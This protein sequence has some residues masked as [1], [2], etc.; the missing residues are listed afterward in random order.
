LEF[1]FKEFL[2]KYQI[3]NQLILDYY[4]RDIYREL[5]IDNKGINFYNFREYINLPEYLSKNLFRV[6]SDNN[7]II[8][9]NDFLTNINLLYEG[10]F[11]QLT[12]II[13]KFLDF[14]GDGK[15]NC[16]DVKQI[17]I[18][19]LNSKN[20]MDHI[21]NF[22]EKNI[23]NFF[24][25]NIQMDLERFEYLTENYN[26]DIFINLIT[27]FYE[28][29]PFTNEII[30]YYFSDKRIENLDIL[31]KSQSKTNKGMKISNDI[32]L[33]PIKLQKSK[34]I[35]EELN[36]KKNY[37][38]EQNVITINEP[39]EKVESRRSLEKAFIKS[40]NTNLHLKN[41][42]LDKYRKIATYSHINSI[43]EEED[44]DEDMEFPTNE[45][46]DF[47]Y[48]NVPVFP[49]IKNLFFQSERNS[50]RSNNIPNSNSK[51]I[52]NIESKRDFD[53]DLINSV[54]N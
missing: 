6:F 30:S 8:S 20:Q 27:Y 48:I 7:N 3:N 4:F 19:S 54:K 39:D 47:E 13:F 35:N 17:L 28:N 34:S 45:L 29:K 52:P 40:P 21:F 50:S 15:I 43:I 49:K 44:V 41:K 31:S 9:H 32:Y 33:N 12:K 25:E 22:I 38:L 42:Y 11:L 23:N 14:D 53:S 37:K 2:E 16:N 18:L 26:S 1:D 5:S 24:G 51:K 36:T 46:E 10:E